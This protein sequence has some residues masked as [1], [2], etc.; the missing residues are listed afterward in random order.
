MNQYEQAELVM[1][2]SL[3]TKKTKGMLKKV[4]PPVYFHGNY[5]KSN[6][7]IRVNNL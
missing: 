3:P 7:T 4:T 5:N 2:L 6:N 1:A